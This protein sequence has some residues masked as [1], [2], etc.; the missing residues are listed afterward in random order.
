MQNWH[1]TQVDNLTTGL[2]NE[3]DYL[4]KQVREN[5]DTIYGVVICVD[6]DILVGYLA[7]GTVQTNAKKEKLYADWDCKWV[8]GEWEIATETNE[9]DNGVDRLFLNEMRRHY[10]DEIKPKFKDNFDYTEE[11]EKNLWLFM[12]G[13]RKAKEIL[14]QRYKAELKDTLF[15]L[16][17]PGDEVFEKETAK[18]LNEPSDLLTEMIMEN[19]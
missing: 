13:F 15:Y 2:L 16:S 3:F 12:T 10:V 4:L 19:A 11:R 5:N 1:E 18:K 6:S 17:I 8:P 7:L 14:Q 9:I